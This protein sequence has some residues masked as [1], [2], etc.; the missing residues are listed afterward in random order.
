MNNISGTSENW[1]ISETKSDEP[2]TKAKKQ[3]A[4]SYAAELKQLKSIE[5]RLDVKYNKNTTKH[6]SDAMAEIQNA[7]RSLEL[8]L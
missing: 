1:L 2:K 5:E 4:L 6:V 7:I 8:T 3:K